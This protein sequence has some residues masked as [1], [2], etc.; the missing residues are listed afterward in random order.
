MSTPFTITGSLNLPGD[1]GLPADPIPLSASGSFDSEAK[2]RLVLTGSGTHSVDMGTLPAEG[3]KAILIKV[4]PAI[5]PA[6]VSPVIVRMNGSAT[7]GIELAAGGMYLMNNP[8]PDAGITQVDIDY[9]T[10]CVVRV[11]VLG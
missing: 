6:V 2:G 9:I 8:A 7:G 10:S 1:S 3:A 4:D 11:W 5:A